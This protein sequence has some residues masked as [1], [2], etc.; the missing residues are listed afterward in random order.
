MKISLSRSLAFGAFAAVLIAFACVPTVLAEVGY[1]ASPAKLPV[2]I[3][4]KTVGSTT[5][6]TGTKVEVLRQDG[7]KTL[8]KTSAG[9][10]WIDSG[11]VVS[12]PPAQQPTPTNATKA[13]A[14]AI[15]PAPS[16]AVRETQK[17]PLPSVKDDQWRLE[18]IPASIDLENRVFP[19]RDDETNTMAV[20]QGTDGIAFTAKDG[21]YYA[22]R[23]N[24]GWTIQPVDL[25][26]KEGDGFSVGM[27]GSA[28]K[29]EIFYVMRGFLKRATCDGSE[30]KIQTM[31]NYRRFGGRMQ[32]LHLLGSGSAMVLWSNDSLFLVDW[33]DQFSVTTKK[34]PALKTRME[35]PGYA[36]RS[37]RIAGDK[38]PVVLFEEAIQNG[39]LVVAN[40]ENLDWSY[41]IVDEKP[42]QEDRFFV[43][44]FALDDANRPHIISY[45]SGTHAIQYVHQDPKDPSKLT[46]DTYDAS[47]F[48]IE[49]SD[50]LAPGGKANWSAIRSH[51]SPG[52]LEVGKDGVLRWLYNSGNDGFYAEFAKGHWKIDR[53]KGQKFHLMALDA[54]GR[55]NL[56]GRTNESI[57]IATRTAVAKSAPAA[58]EAQ[59]EL[60]QC[61]LEPK[62]DVRIDNRPSNTVDVTETERAARL[63]ALGGDAKTVMLSIQGQDVPFQRWGKGDKAIV[64]FNHTGP[65]NESVADEIL[66]FRKLIESGYS[67]ISWEYPKTASPF[68]KIKKDGPVDFS[69]VASAVVEQVRAK[70]GIKDVVLVGNSLGAGIVL[71]DYV[72]LSADTG[73]SFVLIS[74]TE[75]YSPAL[76]TLGPLK[77]GVMVANEETDPFVK[78]PEVTKW[79]A[80]NKYSQPLQHPL[81]TRGHL[82]LGENLSSASA[83]ELIGLATAPTN[84]K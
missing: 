19:I 74:P 30:W 40:Y 49:R 42:P 47:L 62:S 33:G 55:I 65:M 31:T 6:A 79:I 20:A 75:R 32:N 37:A 68:D 7:S 84:P 8:V 17:T 59:V 38:A 58:N 16:A 69:D 18:K 78:S 77:N 56:F 2:V 21:V 41:R 29:P 51:W 26:P 46:T 3:G 4:G 10:A 5:L 36:P 83:A 25:L 35:S 14:P 57:D 9:E 66:A 44:S 60:R 43:R 27:Q 48:G 1:L 11:Q 50:S 23:T 28:A 15:S 39:P 24:G 45:R 53:F 72:K 76:P 73:V 61:S 12:D 67:V 34:L 22:Q 80:E 64:F 81:P 52:E 70:C 82:I 54:D 63:S 13:P 71:W